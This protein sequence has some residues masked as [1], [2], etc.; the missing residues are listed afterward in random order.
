MGKY[1]FGVGRISGIVLD[2]VATIARADKYGEPAFGVR[3]AALHWVRFLADDLSRVPQSRARASPAGQRIAM[4]QGQAA[5]TLQSILNLAIRPDPRWSNMIPREGR[6]HFVRRYPNDTTA[7][8][9]PPGALGL[10]VYDLASAALDVI[11]A[12]DNKKRT[13]GLLGYMGR[14]AHF[15]PDGRPITNNDE[16][17]EGAQSLFVQQTLIELA[18]LHGRFGGPAPPS[19]PAEAVACKALSVLAGLADRKLPHSAA[20]RRN[21]W[22]WVV[23]DGAFGLAKSEDSEPF[24]APR[25]RATRAAALLAG[26]E[27]ELEVKLTAPFLLA[28]LEQWS[29]FAYAELPSTPLLRKHLADELQTVRDV[30]TYATGPGRAA[31]ARLANAHLDRIRAIAALAQAAREPGGHETGAFVDFMDRLPDTFPPVLEKGTHQR[32]LGITSAHLAAWD[33]AQPD[34]SALE[35]QA[36]CPPNEAPPRPLVFVQGALEMYEVDKLY[37]GV[38]LRLGLVFDEPYS[39]ESYDV[40]LQTSGGKSTLKAKRFDQDGILYL[41]DPFTLGGQ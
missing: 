23:L 13:K 27:N 25:Y 3:D 6:L 21:L 38:P 34:I 26:L 36:L 1:L 41:T 22:A 9:A 8:T 32:L 35:W 10:D 39:E 4:V 7:G 11:L 29:I 18:A 20:L 17:P 15:D 40:E 2:L 30:L 14:P 33:A 5:Y 37:L 19:S 31:F 16:A 24:H 28:R 12:V